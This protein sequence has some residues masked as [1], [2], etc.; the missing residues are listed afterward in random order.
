MLI[1][2]RKVGQSII[3]NDNIEIV[4]TEVRGD[5]VRLGIAAPKSVPVRRKEVLDQIRRQNLEAA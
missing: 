1:L 4:V 3:I 2:S 5:N